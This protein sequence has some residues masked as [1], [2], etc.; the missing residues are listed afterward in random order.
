MEKKWAGKLELWT[1]SSS[2]LTLSSPVLTRSQI[3]TTKSHSD[4]KLVGVANWNTANPQ[5]FL[6]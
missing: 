2:S 1:L 3:Q 4:A 6:H 5:S